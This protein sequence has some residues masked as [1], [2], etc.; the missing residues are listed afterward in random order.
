[1][2]SMLRHTPLPTVGMQGHSPPSMKPMA[3]L[4]L[5]QLSSPSRGSNCTALAE[6]AQKDRVHAKCSPVVFGT[7]EESEVSQCQIQR[8]GQPRMHYAFL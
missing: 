5:Q 8:A 1:M 7:L 2:Q 4:L 6:K 3:S